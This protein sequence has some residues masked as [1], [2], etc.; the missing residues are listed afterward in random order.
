MP[1]LYLV[2]HA[3]ST[4]NAQGVLAGRLPGITLDKKGTKQA[5]KL[6][7]FLTTIEFEK[8]VVSPLERTQETATILKPGVELKLDYRIAECDYGDWSGK[9]ITDLQKEE[10]WKAV[11]GKPSEVIFPKGESMA[12]MFSRSWNAVEFW[13]EEIT[14]NYLMVSHADVIKSIVAQSLGMDLDKFQ[15]IAIRPASLTI[16]AFNPTP[17]LML[18]NFALDNIKRTSTQPIIGGGK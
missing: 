14:G 3:Q 10:L 7:K 2:R 9:K 17:M 4:A 8:I 5:E 15:R 1:I 11:Q 18:L 12:E 16:I 13:N 6:A